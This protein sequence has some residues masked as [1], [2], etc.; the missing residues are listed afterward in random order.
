M[1]TPPTPEA[2]TER[3]ERIA[4]E[5]AALGDQRRHLS[6]AESAA[7]LAELWGPL[8]DDARAWA[9]QVLTDTA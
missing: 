8:P 3:Y 6:P 1:E 4:A 9:D 7:L 5:R 2:V